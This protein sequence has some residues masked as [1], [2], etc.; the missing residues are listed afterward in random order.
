M[1]PQVAY[2]LTNMLERVITN[3]TGAT[4][5]K[6]R[7]ITPYIA[8][9]TGSSSEYRDGIFMG[10]TS[11][12]VTGVWTGLDD[13]HSMGRFMVG[14][15]T[16]APIWDAY[17]SKALDIYP[18]EAFVIPK[19]IVFAEI[20]PHTGMIADSSYKDPVLMPYVEGTEPV[21]TKKRE[22]IKN[23]QSFFGMF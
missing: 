7:N 5:S 9:K 21:L 8:G 15:I 10:Y 2:V 16:A 17:M 19:G 22:K 23:P 1:S 3:G 12:L 18:P 13:F 6:I 4:V 14:A 20:N 11:S